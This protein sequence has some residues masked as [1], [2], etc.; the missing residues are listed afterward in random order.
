M[1]YLFPLI[2]LVLTSSC[3]NTF[4]IV[5]HTEK[6]TGIDPQTMKTFTDPPLTIEGQERAL[7]LKEMLGGKNIRRFYSTNTLRTISTAVAA[8]MRP[9]ASRRKRF[10]I[11]VEATMRLPR[12]CVNQTTLRQRGESNSA[13]TNSLRYFQFADN[14][15]RF[16]P[17]IVVLYLLP[18]TTG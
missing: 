1:K 16:L 5:R 13:I 7:K 3:S 4:Y 17:L 2:I 6:A 10:R 14:N 15:E 18:L 9:I 8:R 12:L 11:S